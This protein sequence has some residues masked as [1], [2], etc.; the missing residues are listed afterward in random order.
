LSARPFPPP[1]NASAFVM[2]KDKS[3]ST[4]A[5]WLGFFKWRDYFALDTRA[6][7]S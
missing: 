3:G 7:F 4:S 6:R 1:L 5:D 2:T